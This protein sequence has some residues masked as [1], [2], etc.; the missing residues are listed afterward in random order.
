VGPPLRHPLDP[1]WRYLAEEAAALDES[2]RAP[3]S[4]AGRPSSTWGLIADEGRPAGWLLAA[5]P[6]A[7]YGRAR[8]RKR[9]AGSAT[10][11]G[12]EQR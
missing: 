10:A 6:P 11:G 12:P 2:L 8:G 4:M 3:E 5:E 1:R 9:K 7:G